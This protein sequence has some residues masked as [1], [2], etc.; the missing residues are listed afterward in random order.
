MSLRLTILAAVIALCQAFQVGM[1]A[2][3]LAQP[4]AT[5][6]VAAERVSSQIVMSGHH[7]EGPPQPLEIEPIWLG[8]QTIFWGGLLLKFGAI[9]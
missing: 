8:I 5:P 7:H 6:A 1:A 2:Q 4:A 9:L 3:R